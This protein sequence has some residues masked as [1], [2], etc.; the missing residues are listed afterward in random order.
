MAWELS[1]QTRAAARALAAGDV[2]RARALVAALRDDIT[3]LRTQIAGWPA[4][5][6]LSADESVLDDYLAALASPA[7]IR[8]DQQ[9]YLSDSLTYAAFRKLQPWPH[10]SEETAR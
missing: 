7:A 3:E 5:P 1:R 9:R 4:D 8:T 10:E 2:E 6:A